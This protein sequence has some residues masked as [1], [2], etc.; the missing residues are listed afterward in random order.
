MSDTEIRLLILAGGA[1][2]VAFAWWWNR[3]GQVT[4]RRVHRPDLAPGVYL[5]TSETC[6]T[7]QSTRQR[8]REVFGE[9][10]TEV[11]F[12]EDPPGFGTYRVARVPTLIIVGPDHQAV[13]LE[14]VPGGRLLRR[15][16]PDGP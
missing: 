15:H 4:T 9:A 2:V 7:C 11:R 3:R 10:V 1:L 5:F 13:I 12:E 6:G 14:G 8:V 16:R